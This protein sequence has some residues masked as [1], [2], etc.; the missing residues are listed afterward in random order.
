MGVTENENQLPESYMCEICKPEDHKDLLDA[1]AKGEKPWEAIA[2]RRAEEKKSKKRKGGRRGR[3]SKQQ[4][5]EEQSTEDHEVKC[6]H[7]VQNQTHV[8]SAEESKDDVP[9]VN[10]FLIQ[11]LITC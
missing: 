2:K 4:Q 11:I 8:A 7:D 9:Q 6:V 3:L 5:V 10:H 1:I